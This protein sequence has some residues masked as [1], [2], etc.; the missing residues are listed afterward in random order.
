MKPIFIILLVVFV[1]A[2]ATS[3]QIQVFG[4]RG[5]MGHAPEN[6]A[7]SVQKALAFGVDGIE[8]DVFRCQSSEIVVFH[9]KTLDKLTNGSGKVEE[10]TLQQLTALQVM[11][12]EPI[13][14]LDK[15]INIINGSTR[16]NIELKGKN[17]AEGVIH[18]MK[19]AIE[20]GRWKADQL[21]VS[22][23][24]WDELREFKKNTSEFGIAIL[25]EKN[26]LDAIPVARE[27]NAFAINPNHSHLTQETI[28]YIHSEGFE[29]HTWTVNEK[30]RIEEL[31]S[32]GVDA[33]ITDFPDR[34]LNKKIPKNNKLFL[35]INVHPIELFSKQSLVLLKSMKCC[36]NTKK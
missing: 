31:I 11:G 12:S 8:I 28:N 7:L 5:A 16:L 6:T 24:D 21:F 34:I 27:L 1:I 25:T 33:I 13:P 19:K 14:T 22:S 26:P 4:H 10:K 3:Q 32:W 36:R 2:S 18:I 30:N 29:I 23:F 35:S 17:T 20:S 9:D 15:I